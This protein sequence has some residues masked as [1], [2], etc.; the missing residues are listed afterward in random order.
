[1]MW[2]KSFPEQTGV[3]NFDIE[4]RTLQVGLDSG[5]IVFYKTSEESKFIQY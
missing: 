5:L 4:T 3:V 1:M 2:A